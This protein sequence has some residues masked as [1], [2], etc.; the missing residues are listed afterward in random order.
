MLD[1]V[2]IFTKADTQNNLIKPYFQQYTEATI[3]IELNY[4]LGELIPFYGFLSI[5]Q[6]PRGG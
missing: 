2:G 3:L 6:E 4:F 5:G 1:N